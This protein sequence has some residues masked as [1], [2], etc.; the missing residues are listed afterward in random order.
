MNDLTAQ[1]YAKVLLGAA[2]TIAAA[3]ATPT[4][5]KTVIGEIIQTYEKR[6]NIYRV[7]VDNIA[8]D[9][10]AQYDYKYHISDQVYITIVQGDYN[11]EKRIVGKLNEEDESEFFKTNPLKDMVI[12]K[13]VEFAEGVT[14]TGN[15]ASRSCNFGFSYSTANAKY[16]GIEFGLK[17]YQ[18]KLSYDAT[19]WLRCQL[20]HGTA[21]V[22]DPFFIHGAEL[23]GNIYRAHPNFHFT[24]VKDLNTIF[25]ETGQVREINGI[26]IALASDK[27]FGEKDIFEGTLYKIYL[28]GSYN[29][30]STYILDTKI[31][32]EPKEGETK[33]VWNDTNVSALLGNEKSAEDSI[34]LNRA[35]Q[36]ILLSFTWQYLDPV[37]K[38]YVVFNKEAF[39]D[40]AKPFDE[41]PELGANATITW[42]RRSKASG[43]WLE[44]SGPYT[45]KS[46]Y[47]YEIKDRYVID[48]EPL[49]DS[50]DLAA[51]KHI[52]YQHT[53]NSDGDMVEYRAILS[54]NNLISNIVYFENL[55]EPEVVSGDT[56]ITPE[57]ETNEEE[58]K[59]IIEDVLEEKQID[60]RI[61]DLKEIETRV[62]E[63]IAK[64][65]EA[66]EG[67][68]NSLKDAESDLLDAQKEA[69]EL[70]KQLSP[71]AM[72]PAGEIYEAPTNIGD[73]ITNQI[74]YSSSEKKY[75]Y[76]D[77]GWVKTASDDLNGIPGSK[78]DTTIVYYVRSIRL[79]WYYVDEQNKWVSTED[80]TA[81]PLKAYS[82]FVNKANEMESI[83]ATIVGY[84]FDNG[85]SYTVRKQ[86]ATDKGNIISDMGVFK[87]TTEDTLKDLNESVTTNI[88]SITE[89]KQENSQIETSISDIGQR[90]TE[91]VKTLTDADD[92]IIGQVVET[93]ESIGKIGFR[94][95]KVEDT[96]TLAVKRV[97]GEYIVITDYEIAQNEKDLKEGRIYYTNATDTNNSINYYYYENGWKSTPTFSLIPQ[98]SNTKN[99][100][101]YVGP[102]AYLYW[103]YDDEEEVK[104]W[105]STPDPTTAG[106]IASMAGTQA[107]IDDYGAKINTIAS[108]SFKDADGNT[109]YGISGLLSSVDKTAAAAS[110]NA[111]MLNRQITVL[112][113]CENSI[114]SNSKKY[115]T[116]KY[117]YTSTGV[118]YAYDTNNSTWN[119]YDTYTKFSGVLNEN[120][121][122]YAG[123]PL[124]Q[125][126]YYSNSDKAWKA[127]SNP[128]EADLY[129]SY[130]GLLVEASDNSASAT[131]MVESFS[132]DSG[133]VTAASIGAKIVGEEGFINAIADNIQ[134]TG[135]NI[136]FTAGDLGGVNLVQSSD[137]QHN[138][139]SSQTVVYKLESALKA[140]TDY[141]ISVS[142]SST[143]AT[144]LAIKVRSS[145]NVVGYAQDIALTTNQK[146][147]ISCPFT[148]TSTDNNR[149]AI[150]VN[151]NATV[152]WI[153]LEEGKNPSPWSPAAGEKVD[154]SLT[155]SGSVMNWMMSPDA[156]VWW[157]SVGGDKENNYLM[158]LD[159]N[160]L[161][162][163]GSLTVTG[164][165]YAGFKAGATDYS[166]L[167]NY[168]VRFSAND[169][170]NMYIA[171]W[172][173]D[174]NSMFYNPTHYN[175][176]GYVAKATAF[177]C[178]TGWYEYTKNYKKNSDGT[179]ILDNKTTTYTTIGGYTPTTNNYWAFKLG[180][181]FGVSR[182]G[183]LHAAN[184]KIKGNIIATEGR[185]A[186]WD[187]STYDMSPTIS[188]P[189]LSS[190]DADN[191]IFMELYTRGL[192]L[193]SGQSYLKINAE[194]SNIAN[195]LSFS[196][197]SYN[198]YYVHFK[199]NGIVLMSGVDTV[200]TINE[201]GGQLQGT[202]FGTEDSPI[203]SDQFYKNSIM[204][205]STDYS[206]M[207][208]ALQPV[209]YKYNHGKSDRYHLGFIA[210]DVEAA[211]LEAGLTTQDFAGYVY[212]ID[213]DKRSLRYSEFIALNTYEIQKLKKRVAELEAQLNI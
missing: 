100:V 151:G 23:P 78:L 2:E 40:G 170:E 86:Q 102:E 92:K 169:N 134:L 36:N 155:G 5:D 174:H 211:I 178:P 60:D 111:Q 192:S 41:F 176:D 121:I 181:D 72:Y 79:Y 142:I 20:K 22:G 126:Y 203:L 159:N 172:G 130:G 29:D 82:G 53:E 25:D 195:T 27:P 34:I 175:A 98:L 162:L 196:Y 107:I 133:K 156:C 122:Y 152:H 62:N 194:V 165:L 183:N 137:K 132:N 150:E 64:T 37:T 12:K 157:N 189:S 50:E 115:D 105:V 84:N 213:R 48:T 205:L 138:L 187:I 197:N 87:K 63:Q 146:K 83:L 35:T 47:A 208:D 95:T 4:F 89:I 136:T 94:L 14:F 10:K 52:G 193:S 153:K 112:V 147:T 166:N 67:L 148:V 116:S 81:T 106:L 127:T 13:T 45:V 99:I 198:G 185:I 7:K 21:N 186:G 3:Q 9:A 77:N 199:D 144:Q 68:N 128:S 66:V 57:T 71:L 139:T 44:F 113:K 149:V 129:G 108:Y 19:I 182:Y 28:G 91:E 93:T 85:E 202:W 15:G 24:I 177:I 191:G 18:T 17:V 43:E 74:Y 168:A 32:L 125:Y 56:S 201:Y 110:V 140:N 109:K 188:L 33:I 163:R 212:D 54:I 200:L 141:C 161:N 209:I 6:P 76:Y 143:T 46:E 26:E 207:F 104:D 80:I 171:G 88:T 120:I 65:N 30:L 16:I 8:F 160:G 123:K 119:Q 124:S 51:R 180:S 55:F 184:A 69:L 75:L 190:L 117:Y 96:A 158:K 173:I 210:Q 59:N 118:Y 42:E 164:K 204:P 206:V 90:I 131:M 61:E 31:A 1:D 167:D 114:P 97:T 11:G 38:Q 73:R 154:A 39:K 49:Y 145:S 70:R 101:Y 58:V 103:Y 179:L 135:K